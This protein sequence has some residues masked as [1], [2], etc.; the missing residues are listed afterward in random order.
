MA[1][2]A[3]VGFAPLL[4]FLIP[5]P[6]IPTGPVGADVP[7][8]AQTC[9]ASAPASLLLAGTSILGVPPQNASLGASRVGAGFA[10]GA[11][12]S[13]C[14]VCLAGAGFA[15]VQLRFS[16]APPA[17]GLAV[18]DGDQRDLLLAMKTAPFPCEPAGPSAPAAPRPEDSA[19]GDGGGGPQLGAQ[20][21]GD[22]GTRG[23]W[24]GTGGKRRFGGGGGLVMDF[25]VVFPSTSP[26]LFQK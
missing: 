1:R 24:A 18:S 15:L 22:A 2:G 11:R 13:G 14:R 20:D 5:T 12:S 8:P 4:A 3:G 23:G 10:E 25:K 21:R 16:P 26:A 7:D 6:G 9:C 19:S 17:A